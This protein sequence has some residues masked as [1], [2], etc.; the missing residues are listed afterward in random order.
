M[1]A[2]PASTPAAAHTLG[3]M[4]DMHTQPS[5]LLQITITHKHTALTHTMRAV[6]VIS[7][8]QGITHKSQAPRTQT[9]TGMQT[10]ASL[11]LLL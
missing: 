10:H 8:N 5:V 11:H 3:H 9:N 4:Q 7:T 1:L 2:L 6:T